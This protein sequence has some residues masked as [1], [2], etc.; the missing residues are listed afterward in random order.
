LWAAYGLS[1]DGKFN[2]VF[3]PKRITELELPTTVLSDYAEVV[4]ADTAAPTPALAQNLRK[5]VDG[6]GLLMIF[7]GDRTNATLMNGTLSA[8]G[9]LP[10]TIG[11]PVRL[12]T[13][14]EM[15]RGIAFAPEGYTHPILEKFRDAS[16]TGADYG[17]LSVQ[18]SEYFKLGVPQ[19]GSVET[20]LRYAGADGRPGDAAIVAKGVG[21]GRVVLFASS[22]DNQ[23]NTWGGKPSYV[24]VIHELTYYVLPRESEALTLRVGDHVDLSAET[25][26]PG[27]WTGPRDTTVS[28]SAAMGAGGQMR[29]GSEA[30]VDTGLYG[31]PN[32]RAVVAVNPDG[33]EADIRHVSAAQMAAALG[34]DA[35]LIDDKPTTLLVPAP[36]VAQSGAA[37]FGP[38][39][40]V[41]A[42]LLFIAEALL[43]MLFSTYR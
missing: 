13:S 21:K 1:V 27:E 33:A 11:Q 40:I 37:L 7:P 24:P 43:A 16:K 30:L 34:V 36:Q 20:L 38:A 41:G 42:L 26:S 39:L 12:E 23:W 14:A 10:A 5:F 17:F 6:G 18:T 35:K 29:L 8:A 3:A 25:A 31:P 4:L 28:V 19:D 32:G 15:A 9:L 2:S 22:A